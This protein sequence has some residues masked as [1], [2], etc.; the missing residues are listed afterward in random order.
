MR[1]RDFLDRA[2][3]VA[4]ALLAT[5]V[6]YPIVRFLKPVAGATEAGGPVKAARADELKP[7]TAKIFPIGTSPGIIIR[8]PDGS[9]RAFS[10]VCTHLACTV[11]YRSTHK[12][13]WCACHNGVYDLQ[14][15]NVSGPPP[16]P[17]DRYP[18]RISGD[19][20]VVDPKSSV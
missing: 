4:G 1:R 2:L 12:D 20:V 6:L 13:I 7:D 19:A 3:G 15:R 9:Y 17:L 10:A 11:Q 18:V 8:M 5:A 14:G 16:R